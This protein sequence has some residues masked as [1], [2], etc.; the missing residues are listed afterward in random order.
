MRD[1]RY[2]M[3]RRSRLLIYPPVEAAT[4]VELRRPENLDTKRTFVL[5][6][7]E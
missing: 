6:Y 7:P 2:G 1:A 4:G 5:F 3:L